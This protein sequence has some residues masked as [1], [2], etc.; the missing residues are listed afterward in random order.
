MKVFLDDIRNIDGSLGYC[1]VRN[2]NQCIALLDALKSDIDI[3]SMD[4][5]LGS[6]KNGLDVLVYMN[7]YD[8]FIDTINIH[9]GSDF[10]TSLMKEYISNNFPKNTNLTL[11]SI[12]KY[13]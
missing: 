4:Y 1:V 9:S 5:N 3:I 11:N 6:T 10:G 2:Y 8:I 7:K 13:Y 12:D